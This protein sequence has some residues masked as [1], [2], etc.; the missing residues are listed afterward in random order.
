MLTGTDCGLSADVPR[1]SID[2]EPVP[3]SDVRST[4][5]VP[6]IVPAD[7]VAKP[8]CKDEASLPPATISPVGPEAAML[9]PPVT[10]ASDASRFSEKPSAAAVLPT[11]S[12]TVPG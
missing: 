6:E 10:L 9:S 11:V 5:A 3:P 1:P 2:P 4:V 8:N 12:A 7:E